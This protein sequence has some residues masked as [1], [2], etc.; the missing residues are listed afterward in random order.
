MDNQVRIGKVGSVNEAAGTISVIY[1]DLGGATSSDLPVLCPGGV[2]KKPEIGAM[3]LVN[4]LSNGQAMGVILGQF[5]NQYNAPI[6]GFPWSLLFG[7]DRDKNFITY[8]DGKL[9]INVSNIEITGAIKVS[10]AITGST[11]KFSG[12]CEAPNIP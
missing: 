11:A 3:V 1:E 9:T 2:W 10:G 12:N 7:A 6:A 5:T 8:K 4:V